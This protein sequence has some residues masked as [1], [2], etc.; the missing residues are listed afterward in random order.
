MRTVKKTKIQ[1]FDAETNRKAV[2]IA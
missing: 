1:P 2:L